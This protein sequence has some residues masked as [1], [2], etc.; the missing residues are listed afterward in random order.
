MKTKKISLI[1]LA[2]VMVMLVAL[3]AVACNKNTSDTPSTPSE[4]SEPATTTYT[5]TLD[6]KNGET[7]TTVSVAPNQTITLPTPTR[8]GYN[9]S[10]WYTE[11]DGN[12]RKWTQKKEIGTNLTLYAAWKEIFAVTLNFENGEESTSLNFNNGDY[13]ILPTPTN[14]DLSFAGWF[15]EQNGAGTKW[16]NETRVSSSA[17]LYASWQPKSVKITFNPNGAIDANGDSVESIILQP[18]ANQA[19][20]FPTVSWACHTFL[21]WFTNKT[22]GE[23]VVAGTTFE[24]GKILYAHWQLDD[25]H[26]HNYNLTKVVAPTCTNEGYSY[27]YCACGAKQ[28]DK[29]DEVAAL[30]HDF[31]F[32]DVDYFTM[33]VCSRDNC[34]YAARRES[35]REFDEAFTYTYNTENGILQSEIDARRDA[36]F[37][38]LKSVEKYN[39][40]NPQHKNT[41]TY[42]EATDTWTHNNQAAYD[43]NKAF[44]H[45]FYDVFY[46][47]LRY[48][49]EQYQVCYVFYCV[50]NKDAVWQANYDAIQKART[51]MISDYYSLFRKVYETKYREYFFSQEDGWT[52]ED[53]E[54]A[55]V[56][57]DTYGGE[58]YSSIKK[59]V[60]EIENEFRDLS[61]DQQKSGTT[62]PTL[63]EEY[64]QLNNQLA[65]MAG[66]KNY[67]EYAYKNVYDRDYSPEDV[68]KL[69]A[70]AKQYFKKLWNNIYTNYN[71][72]KNISFSPNS[73]PLIYK[74]ALLNESIFSSKIVSDLVGDYLKGM[75]IYD[76]K[77]NLVQNYYGNVNELFEVGNYYPGKYSGAFNYWIEAQQKSVLYFGPGSYSG[78]F[79]FIHEF[80]HYNNS[81]YNHGTSMSYDL[82]ET[83][84]QGNEMMFLAYLKNALP[85]GC[86][87]AYEAIEYD[88]LYNMLAIVM[89]AMCVDEFE[90]AVYTNYYEGAQYEDGISK[91]EYDS[92][93]STIM[94]AYG[95]HG[96]LNSAYWRYVVIE[97]ACYYISYSISAMSSLQLYVWAMKDL[98]KNGDIEETKDMYYKLI[99]FTDDDKNAHT[100]F[101][102]DRVVDI[103]YGDT[104]K[105][106]GLLSP[107]DEEFYTF[108]T[109]FFL[110]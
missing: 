39:A 74:N 92:L 4:S 66:Y 71:A 58:E 25:N 42:N 23:E 5:V 16:T 27:H 70:F 20:D 44:E 102:G 88:Q 52:P 61:S 95:I 12:G 64:V 107:F 53:I 73:T 98:E 22:A 2:L 81:Y 51:D 41:D 84:S 63:Y 11:E 46:D 59:R 48:L 94:M 54:K 6:A 86:E 77:G 108:I 37:A 72:S 80:G 55:L 17:T 100:D 78:A 101:V 85:I 83:H 31:D 35:D 104:L 13:A 96:P 26:E 10:G 109:D 29:F 110:S 3:V 40:N 103:G 15:T 90:Q 19:F 32:D 28:G 60:D 69:R 76:S 65:I 62:V 21:G 47:D 36:L 49:T 91:D 7:P 97:S 43:A 79:T 82:D 18:V 1:F 68:A 50:N 87:K 34:D 45:D 9:F 57:S 14:A 75:N 30:G 67:V 8:S 38:H 99:T 93:F 89:L 105:Y 24:K 33:V 56:L 106:A